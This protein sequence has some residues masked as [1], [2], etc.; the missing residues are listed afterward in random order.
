MEREF[1]SKLLDKAVN[2]FSK[3]PGIGKKTALRLVLHLLKQEKEDVNA[4]G[5]ALIQLKNEIKHCKVCHNISD[6]ETCEICSNQLRDKSIIC[7]VEN[8]KDIMAIEATQSY[9]GTYHVIGG[10]IS[11][12]DGI[13]P[14][15]L[16]INSLVEKVSSGEVKEVILGLS[17]TMEGETTS[18]YI[19]RKLAKYNIEISVLARGVAIGDELSYA[20][21]ITLGRSITNRTKFETTYNE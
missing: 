15:D 6:N 11:P 4:F 18:Y 8:I 13:G 3:L 1:P 14:A 16:N 21:E 12:M 7:V 20:D 10:I 9:F 5:N 2:E 19:F 17:T